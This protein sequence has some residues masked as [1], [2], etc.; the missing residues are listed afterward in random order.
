MTSAERL[1]PLI[2]LL[3][4]AVDR[5][6]A[7][8]RFAARTWDSYAPDLAP[9]L[10]YAGDQPVSALTHG[11]ASAY[12]PAH[13][14]LAALRSF[15]RWCKAQGWLHDDP[16]MGLER[17]PHTRRGPHALDPR[18]ADLTTKGYARL[19]YRQADTL[20]KQ[21]MP[22]WDLHQLRH[23]AIT[24][25]AAKGYTEVELKRFSGHTSLRSMEVY[26]MHNREAAKHKAR[27]WERRGHTDP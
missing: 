22:A 18:Q 19:S 20:W 14:H 2:V 15:A 16:P 23:P 12:L 6:L 25:H 27:E 5:F 1:I 11:V 13:E 3:Q 4:V 17:W 9:L 24:A 8:S 7:R 26:I 10:A 21:Y